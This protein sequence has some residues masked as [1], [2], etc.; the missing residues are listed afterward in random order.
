MFLAMGTIL[1][2]FFVVAA[3]GVAFVATCWMLRRQ[4]KALGPLVKRALAAWAVLGILC[5]H[6]YA[7]VLPQVYV[8]MQVLYRDPLE[9]LRRYRWSTLGSVRGLSVGL[10]GS[11][12][13]RWR[14]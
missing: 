12:V 5:F 2:S 9:V 14:P 10:G 3:H 11:S 13:W 1:Y 8:L 4:G 6:L 7:S